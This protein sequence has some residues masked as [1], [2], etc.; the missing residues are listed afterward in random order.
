MNPP[1]ASSPSPPDRRRAPR[2]SSPTANHPPLSGRTGPRLLLLLLLA[3]G[4]LVLSLAGQQEPVQ[5]RFREAAREAGLNFSHFTGSTGEYFLPEIMGPGVALFDYD[6]DGDLDVYVLQGQLLDPSRSLTDSPF[7]PPAGQELTHRLFR[8]DSDRD[9]SGTIRLRFRD[10]TAAAGVGHRGYG[11]GV[12]VGDYD[13]DGDP[14]LYLTHF[15]SNLLYRNNGDGTF[16]DVTRQAGVDDPRWSTSA[17]FLDYDQDGHLDLFVTNYLDFTTAANKACYDALGGRDFCNP[18]QYRPVPDRLF[19]NQG[20]GS[21]ADVTEPSGVSMAFGR[22]LGVSCTDFDGDGWPDIYVANDG[23][24]NQ[25]WINRRDGTF[26]ETGL[27]SGT[28]YNVDGMAEG[29]MGVAVGDF[30]N[31]G[32]EDIFLTHLTRET[33]TLYVN[34]GNLVFHDATTEFALATPSYPYTGFGTDWFDLDRDGYLDLFIANGAVTNLEELRGDPY[35]YHQK[36]QLFLN[37]KGKGFRELT[38]EVG[39]PF[40]LSEVS[41]GAAFGDIDND[42][43]VD[44]VVSN[45]NGPLRLLLNE[46][47]SPHSWL[48]VRLEA[49]RGT[50]SALGARVGVRLPAGELL[51]RRVRTD[52]SYLSASDPRILF[53]LGNSPSLDQ[54]IVVWPQGEPEFW[55]GVK[56]DSLLTLRQGTGSPWPGKEKPS[57]PSQ[58]EIP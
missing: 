42:G 51:W 17:C 30:N 57:S 11:M 44:I 39:P 50:P 28:A 7:P 55:T 13:N 1:E 21:F 38:E 15:G 47:V 45:N 24:A 5:V 23:D 29:S 2:R 46:T 41:R 33:N 37:L 18:S 58:K 35:P 56:V 43:D 52:G 34:Q 32:W 14:D 48:Q 20:D 54:L 8:N 31:D 53:G 49:T 12:A 3:A 36:N 25:L 16:T 4:N 6:Q 27:L 22:G 9:S 40:D 19:R 10:V 26:E